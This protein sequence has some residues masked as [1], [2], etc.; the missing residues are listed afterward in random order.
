[1]AWTRILRTR[2]MPG[3]EYEYYDPSNDTLVNAGLAG[4]LKHVLPAFSEALSFEAGYLR[5]F[6][7]RS[8]G[9]SHH[10]GVYSNTWVSL[11]ESLDELFF[12]LDGRAETGSAFLGYLME[13]DVLGHIGR[14]EDCADTLLR[15]AARIEAFRAAHPRRRFRFTL[16]SDHGM[17][18]TS[19]LA[20]NFL[21]YSEELPRV[22]ITPVTSLGGR[23][24]GVYAVPILHVRL[25]YFALHTHPHLVAEVGRRASELE[26]VDFAAGRLGPSRYGL[27][28]GGRLEGTFEHADGAYAL[29]GDFSR[30]GVPAGIAAASDEELFAFTRHGMYP[31]LFYRL[32]TGLSDVGLDFPADVLVSTR[33]GW[34]SAGAIPRPGGDPDAFITGGAHGGANADG[35]GALVSE[36]RDLPDAVR[37]DAFL[38]LFPRLAEHLRANGIELQPPDADAARPHR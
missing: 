29:R 7:Y 6:D 1:V 21:D 28:S 30:F 15:L 8:N 9:Y 17:D 23:T 12:A 5:A 32:R 33:T 38:D 10:F 11:G 37:A 16:L 13:G 2:K 27:W 22:G 31:D 4:L 35:I 18:F 26:S 34:Q 36:E 24:E 25:M 3:Y 19:M 20:R 14:R